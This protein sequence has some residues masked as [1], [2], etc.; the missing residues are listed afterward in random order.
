MSGLSGLPCLKQMLVQNTTYHHANF[1]QILDYSFGQIFWNIIWLEL[2][3]HFVG[4]IGRIRLI[5]WLYWCID[6]NVISHWIFSIVLLAG[7]SRFKRC[8]VVSDKL[9]STQMADCSTFDSSFTSGTSWAVVTHTHNIGL[10]HDLTSDEILT[11]KLE[12][13]ECKA[14]SADQRHDVITV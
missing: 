1:F 9:F 5:C 6:G 12:Q 7:L 11:K 8:I 4:W 10:R 3:Y 14:L 2:L 13:Q